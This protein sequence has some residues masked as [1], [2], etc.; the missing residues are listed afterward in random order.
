MNI[1]CLL[2]IHKCLHL[3]DVSFG[4]AAWCVNYLLVHEYAGADVK[5]LLYIEYF[6]KKKY[7]LF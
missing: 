3:D 4:D 5:V 7:V 6:A 1:G 2:F